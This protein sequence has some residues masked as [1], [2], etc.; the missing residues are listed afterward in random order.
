MNDAPYDA[1][2]FKH[3]GVNPFIDA[4]DDHL[5][6]FAMDVD[7][8][9]YTIARRFIR[10][11]YLPDPEAVRVEEFVNFFDYGYQAA[12]EDDF[13]TRIEGSPSPFGR[14]NYWLMRVGIQARDVTVEN[15][16]DALLILVIDTSGSMAR[17]NRLEL[18]KG[19]VRLLLGQLRPTDEIGI[20]AYGSHGRVLLEPV[21]AAD[22]EGIIEVIDSLRA[23]G[24]TNAEEGLALAYGLALENIQPGRVTRVLLMSDGV[25]NEGRT[26]SESILKLVGNAVEKGVTLSTVGF[27]MGNYN[28]ILMERLADDGNGN[29]HYVDSLDEARRVL[30]ENLTQT[31]QVVARDAKVQV[32]FNPDVVSR[33]RLLGYENRRVEDQEFR[34][35]SVDAGEVGSGHSVTALYEL[36]FHEGAE[37]RV[38]TVFVRYQDP[39]SLEVITTRGDLNRE[40]FHLAFEDASP[41]FQLTATVAEYAEILR[42]S[43]WA[44]DGSLKQVLALANRVQSLLREDAKVAEFASL[45]GRALEIKHGEVAFEG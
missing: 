12:E 26:G 14:E 16:K 25:A 37:G 45:V 2:F 10:D 40:E 43:Y 5:S 33:Y 39:E 38:A 11:G 9:S 20:V 7:T 27:G 31:L 6:T 17:E 4:E 1:A 32:D 19:S 15:R 24:S 44:Q 21:G 13:S 3:Y 23:D 35:D 36:K 18:V 29:Y 42:G 22:K 41:G 34:D 30:V 28:D 8:A